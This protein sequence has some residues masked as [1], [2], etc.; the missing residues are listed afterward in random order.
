MERGG[1]MGSRA[2]STLSSYFE[3]YITFL[4]GSYSY[5]LQETFLWQRMLGARDSGID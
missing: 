4:H 2:P 5:V 1:G 3:K